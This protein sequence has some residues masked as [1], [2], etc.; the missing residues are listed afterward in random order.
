VP[1]PSFCSSLPPRSALARRCGTNAWS[2]QQTPPRPRARGRQPGAAEAKPGR[3][4]LL[5][6]ASRPAH[7]LARSPVDLSGPESPG[8]A[9]IRRPPVPLRLAD[10]PLPQA[11]RRRGGQAASDE[12]LNVAATGGQFRH[13]PGAALLLAG[14]VSWYDQSPRLRVLEISFVV[15]VYLVCLLKLQREVFL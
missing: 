5:G 4:L 2:L 9:S 15:F 11:P 14:R 6:S 1:C 12:L 7:F 13:P 8:S 3:V 10:L